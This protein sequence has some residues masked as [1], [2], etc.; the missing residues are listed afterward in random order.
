MMK[1]TLET[2]VNAPIEKVWKY[3]TEPAYIKQWNNAS[4]DWHT[5][6]AT[7]NLSIGGR[8]SYTMAAKDGSFSFDFGGVYDDIQENKYIAYTLGDGRKVD[9]LFSSTGENTKIT[10]TFEAEEQNPIERQQGG[11]QAIL[12]NF[13]KLVEE[14]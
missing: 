1:I 13:K 9:I 11:W 6:K 14:K 3:F 8:F 12:N 2:L 10:E 7:N 4:D 5:P